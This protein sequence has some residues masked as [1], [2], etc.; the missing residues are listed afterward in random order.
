[1]ST[2]IEQVARLLSEIPYIEAHPGVGVDQVA[3]VFGVSPDQVRRDV[4]VAIFCGLP[5]GY[6]QDLI[7]VDLDVMEDEGALY[8]TNPTTLERPLRLTTT[9]AA[10]LRLALLA[11]RSLVTGETAAVV[12]SLTAKIAA[13]GGGDVELRL[14]AGD[15]A[16]R[17]RVNQA[18]TSVRR[19]RLT[20]DGQ[21]RGATTHPLVD[22]ATVEVWGGAA[23]L[24]AYDVASAG[25]RNYRL[26]RVTD[27]VPT[28]QAAEPHGRPPGPDDWARSLAESDTARLTLDPRAAWIADYH[29]TR[30]VETTADGV[31]VTL[32]VVGQA[33]L[34]RLLLSLGDQVRRVEPV[35]YA[36]A[37]RD[38]A[39]QTLAAYTR[40][41]G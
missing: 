34:V 37:A 39:R 20:Y 8:L 41:E 3:R 11:V 13:E 30:R 29:P 15:P 9:E 23:Y 5:G 22:P 10:S 1:M 28:G 40:L 35:Q 16:I 17:E 21:A 31:Q 33:W 26:D 38:L 36:R 7:D 6:P 4:S 2:S 27:A 12:D 32:P 18:I 24:T 14:A 19:L 25:W